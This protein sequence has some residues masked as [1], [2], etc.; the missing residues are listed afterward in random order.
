MCNVRQH[1]PFCHTDPCPV[2]AAAAAYVQHLGTDDRPAPLCNVLCAC[3]SVGQRLPTE[4]LDALARGLLARQ[5]GFT[6]ETYG[7]VRW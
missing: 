4:V 7:R 3:S 5:G 6:P 1:N 2:V